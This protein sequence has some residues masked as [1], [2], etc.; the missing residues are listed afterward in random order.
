MKFE[1]N[2]DCKILQVFVKVC[3]Y[4]NGAFGLNLTRNGVIVL[5]SI[6][7]VA[8]AGTAYAGIVLP[9]ITLAGNVQVD[10]NLNVDEEITGTTIA[11]MKTRIDKLESILFSKDVVVANRGG[12]DVSVL[13][14]NGDGTFAAQPDVAVGSQ[15]ISVVIGKLACCL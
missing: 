13:L 6:I 2:I 9:M 12:D 8:G 14:G 1:K 5:I 3:R 4:S 15:P 7:F 11:N 10:G